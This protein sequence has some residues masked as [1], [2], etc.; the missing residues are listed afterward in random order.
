MPK[1]IAIVAMAANRII[2][3]DG[4]LP[5]KLSEDLK[6]FKRTTT[7]NTILM[8]RKTWDSIGRPLPG[9]RNVV[10][11]RSLQDVP[12]GVEVLR[13]IDEV[14]Q[15]LTRS[16]T[17]VYLIGGAEIYGQLLPQC[18]EIF[19]SYVFEPHEGDTEF[20]AFEDGFE[21]INVIE[22]HEEFEIRRYSRIK[23]VTSI[24]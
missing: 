17:D 4:D 10:I 14:Q 12:E 3:R 20:P 23:S 21:L 24:L 11:S 5:W 18:Q 16:E 6:F 2:G 9:R 13:S 15:L 7:G 19:L 22:I 1:L 8:G